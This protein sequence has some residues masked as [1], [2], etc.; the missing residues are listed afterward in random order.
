MK[1]IVC[2]VA[3]ITFFGSFC[4]PGFAEEPVSFQK[5]S[6]K[7]MEAEE[8]YQMAKYEAQSEEDSAEKGYYDNYF[9]P[10]RIASEVVGTVVVLVICA[11]LILLM[12]QQGGKKIRKAGR[13]GI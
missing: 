9:T 5:A 3:L 13:S 2:L 8:I 12:L 6:Q 11:G 10:K 7:H 1:N 4:L